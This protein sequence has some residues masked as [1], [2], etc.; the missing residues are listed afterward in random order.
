[1][2]VP[3]TDAQSA[4]GF[5]IEQGRN[6]EAKVYALRY[7]DFNYGRHVTVIT[8]G[9]PWAT[10]TIFF[11]TD[12]VGKANWLSGSSTDMPFNE[13][14]RSKYSRD[15]YMLGSGWE[16][17]LEEINQAYLYNINLSDDKGRGTRRTVEQFLYNVAI[18][19]STE[20]NIT[21]LINS[22]E[23]A[24]VT[25][26]A[27]GV[28]ASTLWSTKTAAQRYRDVNDQLSAV[29]TSTNEVEM[30]SALRLTPTAF[31]QM[32]STSTGQGDG[33]LTQLEFFRRNNV[34]TA[35]TGNDLDIMPLRSLV[36]A[37]LG[38]LDRGMVY[39]K[40]EEVVRFHLPMPFQM[41]APRQKSLMGYE[42]G[43]IAR[44]GGTEW[45]L[46]GAAEYFDG[47]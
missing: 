34:Y 40:E 23:V 10:G 3:F 35:T 46:P 12:T 14:L 20:K 8:E 41:V 7:P 44:T 45:R 30:A 15:F 25:V 4:L 5:V 1:M 42:A 2:R 43:G 11:T 22:A 21:G 26:P 17:N 47:M 36:G 39:R 27:D 29:S 6:I 24:R 32:A 18:S 28:G 38:G 16:W 13:L 33:T 31:R 19:G 9:A 37:G